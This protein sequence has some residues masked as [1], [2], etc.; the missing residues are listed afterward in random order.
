V[1][2]VTLG[3]QDVVASVF[4]QVVGVGALRVQCILC[5]PPDYAER[6]EGC[7]PFT[8]VIP[9]GAGPVKTPCGPGFGR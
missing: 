5:R 2:L 6:A 7:L 9:E 4:A 8:L 1:G 3:D